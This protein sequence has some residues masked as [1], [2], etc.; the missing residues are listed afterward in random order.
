[1]LEILLE[2]YRAH[3]SSKQTLIRTYSRFSFEIL[4]IPLVFKISAGLGR[5]LLVKVKYN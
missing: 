4:W 1:M 5:Y 2:E 3:A